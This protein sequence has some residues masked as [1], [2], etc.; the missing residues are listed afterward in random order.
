MTRAVN[1]TSDEFNRWELDVVEDH[2]HDDTSKSYAL[3]GTEIGN[4]I[5]RDEFSSK[6]VVGLQSATMHEVGHVLGIG[7]AD[8]APLPIPVAGNVVN[9]GL[10]VSSGNGDPDRTGGVD[11]T[12]E[13]IRINSIP[14]QQWSIM[15]T[16]S[17]DTRK[18]ASANSSFPI[19]VFSIEELSTVDFEEI[20]SVSED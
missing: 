2:Y 4:S 9:R 18:F 12:N 10:E 11:L 6:N 7:W 16:I 19:V 1:V 8:D 3:W 13:T 15:S 17:R 20:P 14:Q 5:L